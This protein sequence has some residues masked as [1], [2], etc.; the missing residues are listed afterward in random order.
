MVKL[1]KKFKNKFG[2]KIHWKKILNIF[3]KKY[4]SMLGIWIWIWVFINLDLDLDLDLILHGLGLGF[5]LGLRFVL[6]NA[7]CNTGELINNSKYA[8]RATLRVVS[9]ILEK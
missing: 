1:L 2:K 7:Q 6:A 3:Y 4:M 8:A 9:K 5:G